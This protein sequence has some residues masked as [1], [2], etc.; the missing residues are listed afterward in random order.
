MPW[1]SVELESEVADWLEALADEEFGRVE[2]YIDLLGERGPLLDEPYT[3]QLRGKLRELR[4]YLGSRGHAVRI[5]YYIAPGRRII[6]LTVFR[7]RQQRERAEIER[8]YKAMQRCI[9]ER[10]AAEEDDDETP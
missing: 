3:R 5:S 4:F 9:E 8:A 7:K 2:F 6:L 10:H 1:G